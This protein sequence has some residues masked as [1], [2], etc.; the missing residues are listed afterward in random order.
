AAGYD[1]RL[2]HTR[3]EDRAIL[4]DRFNL[5]IV[6][7]SILSTLIAIVGAL[8]LTGTMSMNVLER[9]REIGIMRAV[10]ASDRAVRQVIVSE[11]VVIGLL[12]W[13][14]GTVI[15][16][17]MSMLMCYGIGINLLGTGLIWTY[18]V[19][20]VVMWLLVVVSLSIVASRLPARNAVQLTVREVLAYE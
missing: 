1:V 4:A 11:G 2:I 9:T 12:A 14:M 7:L 17:P 15:S 6:V 8:G 13:L 5:I 20:A 3:T 18:A 10:G 16:I 19:Y